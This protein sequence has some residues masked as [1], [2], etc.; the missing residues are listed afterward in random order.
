MREDILKT[1]KNWDVS[2][3]KSQC[4]WSLGSRI[5]AW[6]PPGTSYWKLHWSAPVLPLKYHCSN[7]QW[8]SL[9]LLVGKELPSKVCPISSRLQWS[10]I[11]SK[12]VLKKK[13]KKLFATDDLC[14][15]SKDS[16]NPCGWE[17]AKQAVP[18]LLKSH[19]HRYTQN[20]LQILS[21]PWPAY[22]QLGCSSCMW[23]MKPK[24]A[25]RQH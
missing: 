18:T 23:K 9:C 6:A 4:V 8:L 2:E 21:C 3:P 20:S 15:L 12:T 22:R 25:Y 17:R 1:I 10:I 24:L 5:G 19:G 7:L 14:F 16:P 13:K 11:N